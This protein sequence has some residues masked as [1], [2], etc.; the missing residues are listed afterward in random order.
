MIMKRFLTF[1]FS[2]LAIAGLRAANASFSDLSWT[3]SDGTIQLRDTLF[4][5]TP[6]AFPPTGW[7]T[8][9]DAPAWARNTAESHS[10]PAS[11]K[12]GTITHSQSN[13]LSYAVTGPGTLSFWWKSDSESGFDFLS[14][15]DNSLLAPVTQISGTNDWAQVVYRV[16]S[17]A[18]TLR[19]MYNKDS[20]FSEGLDAGWIDDVSWVAVSN[21]LV[22]SDLSAYHGLILN[23]G[24]NVNLGLGIASKIVWLGDHALERVS[25]STNG[26]VVRNTGIGWSSLK[27][28]TNGSDNTGLG[29]DTLELLLNGVH[30]TAI[31][32][33]SFFVITNGSENTGCGDDSFFALK[34]G[35]RNAALGNLVFSTAVIVN[36]CTGI[37]YGAGASSLS[38]KNTFIGASADV[39][40]AGTGSTNFTSI[41]YL[42]RGSGDNT[43]ML[44]NE[45]TEKVITPGYYIGTNGFASYSTISTN[46]I[47]TT[48][49]TNN[50]AINVTVY[51]TATA[52]SFT[53][54]NRAGTVLYTSPTLTA[55]IPVNLQPGWSIRAASGLTGTVLPF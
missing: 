14:F 3:N 16:S 28:L 34:N 8:A 38:N 17:G 45:L 43:I 27:S 25:A 42:A 20:S 29:S 35:N 19:W 30:N 13:I 26:T 51:T 48:G 31:G 50:A 46:Q 54:N 40:A 41:G 44:G 9:G 18:H 23:N 36:D 33:G 49:W 24:T 11:A 1:L 52:V 55:T 37:G 12:S 7:S 22:V 10:S 53:I 6:A 2:L 39:N 21:T 15:L 32:S 47:P 4:N 5:F